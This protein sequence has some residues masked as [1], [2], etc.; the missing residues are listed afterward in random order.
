[1]EKSFISS[2]IIKLLLDRNI[3][4]YREALSLFHKLPE[5]FNKDEIGLG[6]RALEVEV[7]FDSFC[8]FVKEKNKNYSFEYKL[9]VARK[10]FNLGFE[11]KALSVI[12]EM[13]SNE[14]LNAKE[15]H[16]LVFYLK[17]K[18]ELMHNSNDEC[19]HRRIKEILTYL[20]ELF[21]KKNGA[22]LGSFINDF[23]RTFLNI[24]VLNRDKEEKRI[25]IRYDIA[26]MFLDLHSRRIIHSRLSVNKKREFERAKNEK[27]LFNKCSGCYLRGRGKLCLDCNKKRDKDT[28]DNL[29]LSMMYST[30]PTLS[31]K[32]NQS[33]NKQFSI[34][35]NKNSNENTLF[36]YNNIADIK[37]VSVI[38]FL[39]VYMA[40]YNAG[41]INDE[42]E[43]NYN[44]ELTEDISSL[45]RTQIIRQ[46]EESQIQFKEIVFNEQNY[47][48]SIPR[49]IEVVYKEYLRTLPLHEMVGK[50]NG[51][52]EEQGVGIEDWLNLSGITTYREL[53]EN[54]RLYIKFEG[55]LKIFSHSTIM[56]NRLLIEEELNKLGV[57]VV[58][59]RD[60][61]VNALMHLYDM[62]ILMNDN[63]ELRKQ[64]NIKNSF[65]FYNQDI[66][67]N[68]TLENLGV[69]EVL[70]LFSDGG[71]DTD[72]KNRIAILT[73]QCS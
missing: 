47:F 4:S 19:D 68:D 14:K 16:L 1:V 71:Y 43:Y 38:N 2:I 61:Y 34:K 29:A 24:E 21:V 52:L 11:D 57:N 15:I 53:K 41:L 58:L 63:E 39:K 32:N 46:G 66:E 37:E 33:Q 35:I 59:D 23:T 73:G 20:Y 70:A 31:I 62:K 67:F 7:L 8:L 69:G 22:R 65:D 72:T 54:S 28:E 13:L 50:I 25:N 55:L 45:G 17:G 5:Y 12:F 27:F 49:I 18:I 30:T 56:N 36:L 3:L 44:I 6:E 42:R 60:S 48:F 64:L 10:G 40:L 26:E 51:M 9:S